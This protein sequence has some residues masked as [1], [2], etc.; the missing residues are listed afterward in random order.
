[1]IDRQELLQAA[2]S[3][4]DAVVKVLMAAGVEIDY[5]AKR[6]DPVTTGPETEEAETNAAVEGV[7]AEAEVPAEDPE[8]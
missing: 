5:E 4:F 1:M 7:E 6:D 2:G 8:P 3:R